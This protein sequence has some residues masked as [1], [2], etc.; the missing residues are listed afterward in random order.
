MLTASA[1]PKL[2]DFGLAKCA[3][4]TGLRDHGETRRPLT[5]ERERSSARC[6]TCRPSRSKDVPPTRAR[7]IFAFGAVLYEMLTGEKAFAGESQASVMASIL[8][9]DPVPLTTRQ[10]QTPWLLDR[11]VQR[12]LAK[13]PEQRWQSMRD[14]LLELKSIS[15][16]PLQPNLG[17]A[18]VPR[19]TRTIRRVITALAVLG[20]PVAAALAVIYLREAPT[21]APV[22]RFTI[23]TPENTSLGRER[24]RLASPIYSGATL[25]VSP[26]GRQVA[27]VSRERDATRLWLRPLDTLTPRTLAGTDGAAY[28]FWSPDSLTIGFFANGKLKTIGVADGQIHVLADAPDPLGGTWNRAGEIVFAPNSNSGLFRIG[29]RGGS[30]QPVTKLDGTMRSHRWPAFLHGERQFA[31]LVTEPNRIFIG[32]LES[33]EATELMPADSGVI[34][35][36]GHLLFVRGDTLFAQAFDAKQRQV[37]GHAFAV[38]EHV[39]YDPIWHRGDYSASE[40]GV[41]A[42]TTGR[43]SNTQ[44]VWFDRTGKR[45]APIS[46]PANYLNLALSPDERSVATARIDEAG[47][48]D[49][50]LVDLRRDVTS[51]LTLDPAFDWLP[52]WSPD[53]TRIAFTSNRDGPFN[54]YQKASN[55]AGAE[56]P[57]FKSPAVKYFTDWSPDG[58]FILFDNLD[59]RTNLDLWVLPVAGDQQPRPIVVSPFT[60]TS[61]RFSPNGSWI[62]YSSDESGRSEVYVR[63]F[64]PPGNRW[65]ISNSGG[66]QPQ[67]AR[68]ATELFYIAPDRKLMAVSV[69]MDSSAFEASPPKALFETAVPDLEN[70]RNRYTA[71]RDGQ[72]FLINTMLGEETN[73]PITI[74]LNWAAGKK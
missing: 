32:S 37:S 68:D 53:G 23:A 15:E 71:S 55:G 22:I 63:G 58:R 30:I 18:A 72:R 7:D 70:A 46:T 36:L 8:G 28:P 43:L 39:S 33:P 49:V 50:W 17:T 12:C 35:S 31:Y 26:D 66:F 42:Y 65:Q 2:L 40:G 34:Y 57:V 62:A 73:R 5:A 10:P 4:M 59:A 24:P 51:R 9:A 16:G 44:L 56:E 48:R 64:H 3:A 74:V 54:L 14:V 25:S 13:D 67:W 38:A 6:I 27:F 60:D 52:L 61:G 1:A 11:L 20:L 29:E 69:R 47:T 41:L 19:R 21:P 45:L